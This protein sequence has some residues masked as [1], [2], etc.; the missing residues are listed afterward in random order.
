LDALAKGAVLVCGGHRT[1]Q[2]TW[3]EPTVLDRCTEDMLV[4]R[5]PT[6]GPVIPVR[7]VA[8]A[9]AAVHATN[10][11]SYG[12][13]ASVWS[14]DI[15]RAEAYARRLQVGTAYVN[16]HSFTGAMPAAPWT[17]VKSSGTGVASGEFALNHYTRPRSIVIDRNAGADAWWFPMDARLEELGNR[18]SDALLGHGLAA[19]KVPVLLWRRQRTVLDFVRTTPRSPSLASRALSRLRSGR[20]RPS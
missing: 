11:S 17:G 15:P 20:G 3:F 6:F 8:N 19:L 12:L 5:E 14:Q 7:R 2:G 13:T 18:L 1:G 10:A 9:E 4:M 16:N